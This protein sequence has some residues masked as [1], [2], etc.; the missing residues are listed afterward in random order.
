[1][2]FPLSVS[3]LTNPP[4]VK[5]EDIRKWQFYEIKSDFSPFILAFL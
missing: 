5:Q 3:M 1:M 2:F 4:N